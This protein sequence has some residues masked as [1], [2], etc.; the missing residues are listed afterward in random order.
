MCGKLSGDSASTCEY[1]YLNTPRLEDFIVGKTSERILNE[2]TIV[3]LVKMKAKELDKM[4]KEL[5]DRADTI[6][7]EL[8][9]AD[10][11]LDSLHEAIETTEFTLEAP[12]PC[13]LKL[14]LHEEELIAAK[15]EAESQLAQ[16]YVEAPPAN[17]VRRY[18]TEFREFLQDGNIP[19]RNALIRNFA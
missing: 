6:A 2:E 19:E 3:E 7:A 15:E 12:S 10:K 8:V 4:A 14:R 5:A 18:V 16:S 11:R 17:V 1:R 13:I 9:D